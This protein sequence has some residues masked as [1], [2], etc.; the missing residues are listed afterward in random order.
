MAEINA[1]DRLHQF[2]KKYPT[3]KEAAVAL[4]I[5]PSYLSDLVHARRDLTDGILAKLGLKR[6]VVQDRG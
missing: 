6:T 3:Q 1:L 5:T 4:K 2:V